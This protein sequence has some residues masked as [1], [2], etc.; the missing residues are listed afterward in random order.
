[1]ALAGCAAAGADVHLSPVVSR[2]RT[3]GGGSEVEALAGAVRVRRTRPDA[4]VAEWALRPLVSR[5]EE[6]DGDH[7]MR[8]LVPFGI[9]R[10]YGEEHL[11]QLLPIYRYHS[12]PDV[13]GHPEWRLLVFPVLLWS[14]DVHGRVLR[15][16]F[17]IGGVAEHFLSFDRLTFILFPLLLKTERGEVTSWHVLWPIFCTSSDVQ[18]SRGWR[19]WPLYGSARAPSH[20]RYFLLW[21]IF[22]YHRNNLHGTEEQRETKWMVFPLIGRTSAGS[23]WSWSVLWPFFGLSRNP[24]NGFWA[25]DGPWP[26]VRI[27]R[28]G[29]SGLATRT[30]FWPFWSTFVNERLDSTWVVWPLFNRRVERYPDGERH[31]EYFVP[32]WQSWER[33]GP[34]GERRE[35][36]TKLWPLYQRHEEGP[37]WRQALPALNPLWHT[38]VIDDHYAWIYELWTREQGAAGR[39]ERSWGGIWRRESD[40]LEE[41]SYL[42][43]LWSRRKYRAEGHTV[44]ETSLCFGLL[45]W[46]TR[47]DRTS[48]LRPAFPG[49]G[50]PAERGAPPDALD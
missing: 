1:M 11:T 47:S 28:P 27:Q 35:S 13:H 24:E 46:R 6:V 33:T 16:V 18:G 42:A 43:G 34:E 2:L 14:G 36:W 49:P 4:P 15:A 41:R 48:L 29:T 44:R 39:R 10:D 21:P 9:D 5:R 3:A 30:R 7:T 19:V 37:A 26:L 12:F 23:F 31:G 40:A 22:H 25:W 45:R 8:Y 32:L 20:E 38:P 50:W 17:P